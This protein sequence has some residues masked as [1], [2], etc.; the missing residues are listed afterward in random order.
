MSTSVSTSIESIGSR[1][2][3]LA[4]RQELLEAEKEHTRLGDELARRRRELPWLRINR[5]YRIL[6]RA[7]KGRD[8]DDG[9][10]LWIRRHDDYAKA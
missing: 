7:P 9:F 1:E 10:Q 2:E 6:D 3:W 5:E 8:E 4:A